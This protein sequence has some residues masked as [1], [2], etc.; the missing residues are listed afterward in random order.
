MP[1][2]LVHY[3]VEGGVSILELSDPPAKSPWSESS[4]SGRESTWGSASR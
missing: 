1:D 4:P 3:R 2:T